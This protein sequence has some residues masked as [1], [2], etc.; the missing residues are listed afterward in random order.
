MS[1]E[2]A[3][4]P[5][6]ETE[7]F[8]KPWLLPF[9]A[10]VLEVGAGDGRLAL[11]LACRGHEVTALD[12][13][14]AVCAATRDRCGTKVGAV[15]SDFFAF[16]DDPYDVLLF[17]RSLHHLAPLH[18][19]LEHAESLLRPRGIVIAEEFAYERADHATLE[20]RDQRLAELRHARM[21][22]D[23]VAA[24]S[25]GPLEAW[26]RY[27]RDDHGIATGDDMAR[28]FM[29]RFDL[30]RSERAPYLYRFLCA[31]LLDES[32]GPRVGF[33]MLDLENAAIV[34]GTI[35]PIG[36]RLVGRRRLV[37]G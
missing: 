9:P 23:D 24:S 7:E 17:T 19:A 10:R 30:L 18:R 5:I 16:R 3:D 25:E 21:I 20:W 34:R 36:Y 14:E 37:S 13:S 1:I 33:A 15:C 22:A 11:R 4:V 8:I 32:P 31:E 27:Y 26:Q 6:L 12:Q 28:A 35:K 29:L 2:A